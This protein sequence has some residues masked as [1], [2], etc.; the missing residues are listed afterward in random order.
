MA[1]ALAII[2]AMWG[3]GAIKETQWEKATKPPYAWASNDRSMQDIGNIS[4][5]LKRSLGRF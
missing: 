4:T 3:L 5:I 2:M 1:A